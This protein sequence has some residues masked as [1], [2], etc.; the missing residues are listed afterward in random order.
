M[1]ESNVVELKAPVGDV[2]VELLKVKSQT[3]S[4][5]KKSWEADY[6]QWQ[7]RDLSRRLYVYMWADGVYSNIRMDD[8]LCLLVVV[9][10]DDTGRKEVLAVVD[11]YRE[12][13]ASWMEVIK[14]LESQGL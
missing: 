2:L 6:R 8:R 10:S 14:Q 12:S 7:Q 5:L 3:A 9:G 4:R 11:G 13:E 1:N